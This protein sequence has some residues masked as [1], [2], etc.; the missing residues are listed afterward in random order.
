[1]FNEPVIFSLPVTFKLPLIVFKTNE[2]TI[3]NDDGNGPSTSRP[4]PS[5]WP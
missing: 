3:R 5:K 4:Y 2:K 1:M